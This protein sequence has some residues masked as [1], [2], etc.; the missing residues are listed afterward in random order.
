MG[1]K[2]VLERENNKERNRPYNSRYMGLSFG[3][4][5]HDPYNARDVCPDDSILDSDSVG[6]KL[7][8]SLL[9]DDALDVV[10]RAN[11]DKEIHE[12]VAHVDILQTCYA[13]MPPAEQTDCNTTTS[14]S[15]IF[16]NSYGASS[17]SSYMS[18]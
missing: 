3:G 18:D 1:Q 17:S 10:R 8:Q 14:A 7:R 9:Y 4:C 15:E 12:I 2:L 13:P 16:G 5:G 11:K 6:D